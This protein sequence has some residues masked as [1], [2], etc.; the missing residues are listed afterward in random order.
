[1][2]PF[3]RSIRTRALK[4]VRRFHMYL[5]LL[6][7][8]W[9]LL[10]GASGF[11]FNHVSPFWGGTVDTVATFTPKQIETYT[12]FRPIE[13]QELSHSLLSR[14]SS[15]LGQDYELKSAWLHGPLRFVGDQ[16]TQGVRLHLSPKDG[17]SNTVVFR[18]QGPDQEHAPYH[19]MYVHLPTPQLEPLAK[20]LNTL[21]ETEGTKLDVP[22]SPAMQGSNAELRFVLMDRDRKEWRGGYNLAT[23][24]LTGV[25]NDSPSRFNLSLA[26]RRLHT[27]HSYPESI[28]S[29]WVWTLL[30]DMTALSLVIWALT[31]L[32]MWWQIV[33]S[34]TAGSLVLLSTASIAF[35]LFLQ[36]LNSLAF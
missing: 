30:S 33:P 12:D 6:L 28:N 10:Y 8:P 31:G 16:G 14:I 34:R 21:L 11:L 26:A 3:P 23:G 15:E 27:N 36:N 29:K 25:A 32:F 18:K 24:K 35:I 17:S 5:G 1:M 4:L 19:G 20:Q 7:L 2:N 22:L 13:I 9:V